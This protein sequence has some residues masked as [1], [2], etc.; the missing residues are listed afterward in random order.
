MR[1]NSLILHWTDG[2]Q[3]RKA[4]GPPS[5]PGQ[6]L[7]PNHC[8]PNNGSQKKTRVKPRRTTVLSGAWWP[9]SNLQLW[10]ALAQPAQPQ[11]EQHCSLWCCLVKGSVSSSKLVVVLVGLK[12]V[13]SIIVHSVLECNSWTHT[14]SLW[15]GE[16]QLKICS[17]PT[18]SN[19]NTS[20]VSVCVCTAVLCH[21]GWPWT[22]NS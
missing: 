17:F 15:S 5:P 14:G 19:M 8:M 3:I 11:Q 12:D 7:F 13:R 10:A 22:S 1:K 4:T 20:G 21:S 9:Q 6:S 16:P 18:H 2:L